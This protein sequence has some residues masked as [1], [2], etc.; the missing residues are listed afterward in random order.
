MASEI[1]GDVWVC[2]V[3]G[4]RSILP[5]NSMISLSAV[6]LPRPGILVRN[7]VSPFSTACLNDWGG[8]ETRDK[9]IFGPIPETVIT[10]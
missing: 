5:L 2:C 9:P 6:F 10:F 1:A 4:L 3:S 7:A 8:V